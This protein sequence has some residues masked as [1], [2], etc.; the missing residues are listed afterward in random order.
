MRAASLTHGVAIKT[1]ND[2]VPRCRRRL[3]VRGRTRDPQRAGVAEEPGVPCGGDSGAG[4]RKV[5]AGPAT[6]TLPRVSEKKS[7]C[8]HWLV[9]ISSGMAT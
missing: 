7:W 3:R 8:A 6:S 4:V 2:V 9:A 1:V 5:L